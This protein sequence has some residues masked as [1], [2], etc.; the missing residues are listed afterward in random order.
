MFGIPVP[1]IVMGS[2]ENGMSPRVILKFYL[3]Q[4]GDSSRVILGWIPNF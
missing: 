2:V 1:T 3:V 4:N